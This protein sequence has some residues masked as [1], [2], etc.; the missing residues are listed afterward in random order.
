MNTEDTEYAQEAF[1]EEKAPD[2]ITAFIVLKASDGSYLAISDLTKTFTVART[3]S[4]TDI[5]QGCEELRYTVSKIEIVNSVLEGL[6]PKT[7]EG[8]TL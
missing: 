4:L 3:A 2:A 5:R 6:K 1:I 8:P 7:A